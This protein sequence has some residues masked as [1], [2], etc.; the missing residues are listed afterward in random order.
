MAISG[1]TVGL[2]AIIVSLASCAASGPPPR[3]TVNV[4]SDKFSQAVTLEGLPR[5]VVFN[6]NEIFW[7]LR[8]FVVQQTHSARHEIY[9]EWFFPG[10]GNARY[11]AA[12]D[13]AR[14]LVV[15]KILK[16]FLREQMRADRY[17]GHRYR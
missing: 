12:D 9:V 8:S 17:A 1:R 7:M 15:T 2:L 11:F 6:G 13:T 10:H 3:T 14:P 16:E 4:I 5:D